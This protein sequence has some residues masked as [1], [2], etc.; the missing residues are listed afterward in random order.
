MQNSKRYNPGIKIGYL[1]KYLITMDQ[2]PTL[3]AD[4]EVVPSKK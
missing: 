2:G 1:S 3:V 4:L